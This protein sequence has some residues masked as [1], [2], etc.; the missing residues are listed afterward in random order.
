MKYMLV[1]FILTLAVIS[2]GPLWAF[3][4][5]AGKQLV[6]GNCNSCHGSELYTRKDRMVTSRPGLNA[7]VKRCELAL[8]LTWFDDDVGNAAEYLNQNFYHFGK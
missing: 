7:Q 4:A 2:T 8:D 3:D 5:A 1:F 6:N